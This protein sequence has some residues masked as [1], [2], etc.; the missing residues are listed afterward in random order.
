M[1]HLI[2]KMIH[3]YFIQV[4]KPCRMN[5]FNEVKN[6]LARKIIKIEKEADS[7]HLKESNIIH[8]IIIINIFVFSRTNFNLKIAECISK[9]ELNLAKCK[10]IRLA[11]QKKCNDLI[12]HI[13]DEETK[14]MDDVDDFERT[15]TNFLQD[16]Y[17]KIKEFELMIKYSSNS[18]KILTKFVL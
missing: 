14:L 12:Q 2:E 16:K 1:K 13:K 6:E 7:F 17:N 9:H 5:H 8:N 18:Q 4:C 15:E 10:E 11:I 3:S